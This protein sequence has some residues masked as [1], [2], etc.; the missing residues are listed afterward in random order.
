MAKLNQAQSDLLR[1]NAAM[2]PMMRSQFNKS[3]S[4]TTTFDSG[5][6][7]PIDW[8]RVI[9]GDEKEIKFSGLCRMATPLHPTMDQAILDVWTFY[10]PDRLWWA[11]AKNFYGENLDASF[12]P[13]GLY[14]MPYLKPSQ[15]CVDQE[16][17]PERGGLGSL[18]D[19]FGFPVCSK[20]VALTRDSDSAFFMSAGLHRCYQLVYNEY[21]RNSSIQPAIRFNDG[22]YV[23]NEE[24]EEIQQI[25]IANRFPD[26]YTTL[27]REPQAGEDVY[28]T[29][30]SFAPVITR[31]Q[32]LPNPSSVP[33][34]WYD[35]VEGSS[36]A[37]NSDGAVGISSGSTV[38]DE[39]FTINK[40]SH[41]ISPYN[42]W[43]DMTQLPGATIN[44]LRVAITTQQLLELDARSGKRYQQLLYAAFGCLTVD[45]TLSRPQLCGACRQDIGIRTVVQTSEGTQASP[46]GN[47]AAFSQTNV[48]NQ[49]I[50]NN[51]FTEP[52]FII[53]LA[54]V[55]PVVSYS[56]G[57]D[58]LLQ[59]LDRFEHYY[60]LFDNLGN[61][62]LYAHNLY[63]GD[64]ASVNELK[65][66]FGY[67]EAW[68]PDRIKQNRVSGLMRPDVDGTLSSWNYAIHFESTPYLNDNFIKVDPELID[69]TIAVPSE[70]Q[71]ILDCYFDYK[72]SKNMSV[73]SVPGVD[74]I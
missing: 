5:Y 13:D 44:D 25:R 70:P 3:H 35:T 19:Y 18:N 56:Q 41:E 7:V 62:P 9:P 28:L 50:C 8:D 69:R 42:L 61:Q 46:L 33:L 38:Y 67:M 43:A 23:T 65:N 34:F 40:S 64:N 59:R 68:S 27:L 17:G 31:G 1:Y 4:H 45:S 2:R 36:A 60:P 54:C 12:N 71:F 55:R 21:F 30:G 6:I 57:L 47:L 53:T 26:L 74:K 29:L 72:D 39:A 22:D 49:Y 11:H 73:H 10:I 32:E 66:V 63:F 37:D 24:W 48:T 51:A 15:Y 16:E 52:G 14:V 58:P 20:S